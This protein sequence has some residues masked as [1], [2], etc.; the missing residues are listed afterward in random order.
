M[1][2]RVTADDVW[3]LSFSLLLCDLG[4]L[5]NVHSLVPDA[6]GI[7]LR[8]EIS[9]RSTPTL[10]IRM[11]RHIWKCAENNQVDTFYRRLR[12]RH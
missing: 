1:L 7:T 12:I 5:F 11:A 10:P 6:I 8:L 4:T 9:G 3:S 2:I